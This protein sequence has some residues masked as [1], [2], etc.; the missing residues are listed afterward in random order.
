MGDMIIKTQQR[1]YSKVS[2][3]YP[4]SYATGN[5]I[6]AA[7]ATLP[8]TN[9]VYSVLSNNELTS[10]IKFTAFISINTAS[11]AGIRFLGWNSYSQSGS[12]TLWV[13]N[14]LADFNLFQHGTAGSVPSVSLDGATVYLFNGVTQV[15]GTPTA[16]LYSPRLASASNVEPCS[17]IFDA[18]G[19]EIVTVQFKDAAGTATGGILWSPI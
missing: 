13:P 9:V 3:S 12:T 17:G 1:S 18:A 6:S 4:A 11:S 5:G 14:V 19:S 8:S 10:L 2:G 15:A 16:N 7:H